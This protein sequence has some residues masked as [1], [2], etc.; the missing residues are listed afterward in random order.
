MVR[1]VVA[2]QAPIRVAC[3]TSRGAVCRRTILRLGQSYRWSYVKLSVET[4]LKP[5]KILME[6]V[7]LPWK[8]ACV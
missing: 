6:G 4:V 3:R 7:D 8:V 2:S 1:L 5:L